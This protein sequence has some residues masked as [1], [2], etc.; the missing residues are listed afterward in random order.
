MVKKIFKWI[1]AIGVAMCVFLGIYGFTIIANTPKIDPDNIYD[2]LLES[3]VLLDDEGN[4]IESLHLDNSNRTN[5]KYDQMPQ[6]LIDAVV[7]IEDK[8]F[9]KHHGFNLWRIMG[10]IKEGITT[11]HIGGTSTITQQLAR[12]VYL[13][14]S[15]SVRSLARKISEAYYTVLIEQNL[16]K[17]EIIEAYLNTIYLGNNAYGVQSAAQSYFNKDAKDL[18]LL[19]CVSLAA[20]PKAPDNYALVKKLN[21]SEGTSGL[22][23]NQK[24]LLET[25][26]FIYYYNGDISEPRRNMTLKNMK[27]YGYITEEEYN[28]VM[29]QS[30]L[31][32]I[33]IQVTSSSSASSYFVDYL[34]DQLT[35]DFMDKYNYTY[36]EARTKI[37]SGGLTIQTTL[38]S[39]AQSA[40][41]KAFAK[42]S[43]FPTNTS[44]RYDRYGNILGT[45]GSVTLYK[46][47]NY[48][49]SKDEFVVDSDEYKTDADGNLV[50]LKGKRLNFYNT[51]VQ[52][53]TDYSIEFKDMYIFEKGSIYSI[54]GGVILVPQ[55]YKSL[56]GDGNL[57]IDKSFFGAEDVNEKFFQKKG[58]TYVVPATCYQLR[59]KIRQ[60][61]AAMVITD[62]KTGQ[63]KAMVGGRETT[64]RKLYNRAINPRQPGSSIKPLAVYSTALQLGAEAAEKG[65][66]LT[67]T[68][69]DKDEKVEYYGDYWT[70]SSGINDAPMKVNGSKW[71]KNWYKGYKGLMTMRKAVEQSVNTTAVRVLNQVTPEKAASQLE[72]FGITSVVKD[73]G[74]ND[75]NS[76]ALALGGMTK[77]ISPL[78]M[79]NA[80]GAIANAGTRVDSTTYTTV[81]DK[82]G[83]VL[84][85]TKPEKTE[86][87]DPGVAYVTQSI[88][89]ST[90]DKGI[91]GRAKVSG[92]ATCGKTGTTSDSMD[93]WFCGYTPQY[94]AALWIGNDV[95]ITLNAT[96]D[97][98]ASLWSKIMYQATAG[99]SGSLA[100]QP[101]NVIRTDGE[102]YVSGTQKGRTFDAS[103]DE[104]KK[105]KEEEEKKKKEEE[106]K[107]K[108]EEE[109]KKK[110]EAAAQQQDTS[111]ENTENTGEATLPEDQ[112]SAASDD[113]AT[114]PEDDDTSSTDASAQSE[115]SEENTSQ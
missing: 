69:F 71:P 10:A 72:K 30:L 54:Q 21:A 81:T 80:Y 41:E 29:D 40:I 36:D 99:M 109:E 20:L 86:V 51:T 96:S 44:I 1:V 68:K 11:G 100:S 77:G 47:S 15:K 52:G 83:K 25:T 103:M 57:V 22:D 27:E 53:Q 9:W 89:K 110:Q 76:A 6:D 56:D 50:L 26:D 98:V 38:N 48:F 60:P 45:T 8:T 112:D 55:Q 39:K 88:L 18:T 12:N 42:N 111:S 31:K 61:Q 84:L 75:M 32:A 62:Y 28:K 114:K 101:S 106:E 19:E 97:A 108:K 7:S 102:Y 115:N 13:A 65:K 85:E 23:E 24:V 91:A 14:E 113:T 49:N 67:Y 105:K 2:H 74:V 64:G 87:L 66:P 79:S 90:V 34:V 46:Y 95:N 107:K 43:N 59:S 104:E 92:K 82:K 93:I 33:D 3:S 4:V 78:E 37:Y 5:I 73:G 17:E 94:S 63:V 58:D 16:E 70:A 35:A